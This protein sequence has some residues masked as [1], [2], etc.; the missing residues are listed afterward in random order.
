L[1]QKKLR[2]FLTPACFEIKTSE[3]W[4]F[5]WTKLRVAAT[6]P[7]SPTIHRAGHTLS[8]LKK[9]RGKWLMARDANLLA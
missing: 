7:N 4:A 8:V 5:M 3:D 9:E 6:P 2:R 1:S